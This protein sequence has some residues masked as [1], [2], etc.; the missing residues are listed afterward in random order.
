VVGTHP[1]LRSHVFRL[2]GVLVVVA[3][4]VFSLKALFGRA[5]PCMC[6][7]DVHALVFSAPTDPS[8]PSG[9]AAGA[10]AFAAYVALEARLHVLAKAAIFVLAA[11]IALSRVV[12]GVHFPSDVLVGALLGCFLG[13]L[14]S[15]R[16]LAT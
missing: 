14:P 12:L 16:K 6:L 15:A 9:H 1:K 4:A 10:F 3:I 2:V 7:S 8:F 5:R 11:G 13:A